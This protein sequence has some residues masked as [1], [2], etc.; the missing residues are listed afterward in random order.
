MRFLFLAAIVGIAPLAYRG[1][2]GAD[3]A[4]PAVEQL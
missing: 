2:T 1:V 3:S 4:D